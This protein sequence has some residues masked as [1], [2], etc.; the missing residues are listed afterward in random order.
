MPEQI[1]LQI[2]NMNITASYVILFILPARFVLRKVP[3]IFSYV[4]WSAALFRLICP[5]SFESVL[6]LFEIGGRTTKQLSSVALQQPAFSTQGNVISSGRALSGADLA[7]Q[8][9]TPSLGEVFTGLWLAGAAILLGYSLVLLVRLHRQLKGAV[10]EKGNIYRSKYLATPF[11]MGVL[12]PKI[13]LPEALTDAEKEYILLHEQIHIERHDY[14]VKLLS[15]LVLCVHWFNPLVWIAFFLSAK[16]MEMSCDE[17]VIRKLG[18][19]VKKDYSISL[20]S[21]ST[22][23]RIVGGTP[24][25]FGEGDIKGRIRNVLHYK[26]P[27]LWVSIAALAGV[28]VLCLGLIANPR[29]RGSLTG[30]PSRE[31]IVVST[32][33]VQEDR[34]AF[35]SEEAAAGEGEQEVLNSAASLEEAV[36]LA[37]LEQN[38]RDYLEGDFAAEAHTV[39]G[40]HRESI[41]D[42]DG[43][44][45]VTVYAMV[46]YTEF[47]YQENGL[48]DVGGSHMPVAITFEVGEN[49]SYR[50]KEYWIPQDGSYYESSIRKKFPLESVEDAL[51]TQ[52]YIE[53][54]MISCY[55]QAIAYGKLDLSSE[56]AGLIKTI[57][58]SP[59]Q[60]SNPT[61]YIKEH[62]IEY[63]TLVYYGNS[64]LNYCFKLFEQGGQTG[65]EG[66]IMASACRDILM[67]KGM[68]FD[69][70]LYDTGQ[71]W[72]DSIKT[73][74]QHEN[75]TP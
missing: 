68:S 67:A 60:M 54:H 29:V 33:P 3:K 30:D 55:E 34:L 19:D 42:S 14:I 40:T 15:F 17:A 39:L 37:I 48:S 64:T 62:S 51:D 71:A 69:D 13:Y 8:T 20:L 26:K 35:S 11:V 18:N 23:R 2:L 28:G 31:D 56:I 58:S 70:I 32:A 21:L 72:Y 9:W 12:H 63:R 36:S 7:G 16:D 73:T 53:A 44:D 4:L 46:L 10:R 52:K 59:A 38:S 6:S 74:L 25:A 5:W 66:H 47:K 24:L 65:L 75:L 41:K 45:T 50:L 49:N 22:G 57:C 27:A 1:F 43:T 61:A